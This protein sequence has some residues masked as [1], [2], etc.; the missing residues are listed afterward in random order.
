[1]SHSTPDPNEERGH[2]DFGQP[3]WDEFYTVVKGGGPC[4]TQR[5]AHRRKAHEDGSWVR[6]AAVAFA[7]K[8]VVEEVAQ[9]PS[10]NPDRDA[11]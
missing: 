4:N 8:S 10:P 6:E 3:D 7:A 1:M 9:Q 5:I 11:S 2:H